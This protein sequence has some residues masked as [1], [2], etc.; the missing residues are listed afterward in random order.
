MSETKIV[1]ALVQYLSLVMEKARLEKGGPGSGHWGHAG[2]PGSRGGSAASASAASIRT[3]ATAR[4]RQ[5]IAKN[6]DRDVA[7]MRNVGGKIHVATPYNADFVSDLKSNIAPSMR[8]WDSRQ[9]V[10]V[11]DPSARG[12]VDDLTKQYFHALDG[13]KMTAAHIKQVKT[14]VR[15][16]RIKNNQ[17]IIGQRQADIE[18][19][20]ADLSDQIGRYSY[21]SRSARKHDL[22]RKRALFEHVLRDAKAKPEE[23]EDIQIRGLAAAIRELGG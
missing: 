22:I 23:M 6:P 5:Q 11:V 2:R 10:W 18:K 20:I 1:D 4:V 9:K 3:G 19:R 12:T 14:Y 16:T 17:R 13:D 8:T 15:T 7:I 21:S